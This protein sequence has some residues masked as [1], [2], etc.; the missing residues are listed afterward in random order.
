MIESKRNNNW[1]KKHLNLTYIISIM[2]GL[3]FL[4]A[5]GFISNSVV[6]YVIWIVI[7]ILSSAWVLW[8]K[9]RNLGFLSLVI[10]VAIIGIPIVF[11]LSN[12]R[13]HCEQ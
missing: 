10:F 3:Y 4:V 9:G 11:C 8:Q 7:L 5:L 2:V 1:F 12:Q 13:E 6:G